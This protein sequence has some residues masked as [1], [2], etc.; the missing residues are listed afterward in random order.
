LIFLQDLLNAS[1]M[2]TSAKTFRLALTLRSTDRGGSVR[3]VP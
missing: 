1:F 3:V 2:T